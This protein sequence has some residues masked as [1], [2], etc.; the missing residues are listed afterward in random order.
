MPR[1]IR[2]KSIENSNQIELLTSKLAEA[3]SIIDYLA[4]M[5]D[6]DI[7]EEVENEQE[8]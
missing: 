5:T 6:V 2:K 7:P 1:V 3:N 8:I 4:M